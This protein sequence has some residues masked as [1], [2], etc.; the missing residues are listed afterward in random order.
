VVQAKQ[1]SMN[2]REKILQEIRQNKPGALPLPQKFYVPREDE[3][4]SE[5]FTAVLQGIGGNVNRV[6]GWHEV[7]YFLQQ[8]IQSGFEVVNG[9]QALAPYNMENYAVSG[10]ANL[11]S[12]HTVFL[13]GEIAV[14]ENGAV[15]VSEKAMGN[16]LLP[17]ICQDLVL[18]V[19]EKNIVAD[20]H[21][22]YE[23]IK[24]DEEAYG[25]FIAGPSKTADIEQSLVI[26]A[27]GPLALQ[28]FILPVNI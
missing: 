17:F 25:V 21:Q 23:R 3:N 1:E 24:V 7:L 20:M 16:R 22:A 11:E 27:H 6:K 19:E 5:K 8:Q 13:K 26:G 18:V 12:V 9:I 14:A 10:A 4:L 2:S 28:V 15:W